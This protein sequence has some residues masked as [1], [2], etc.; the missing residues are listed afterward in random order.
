MSLIVSKNDGE[1]DLPNVSD[2]YKS[3][4][5][6]ISDSQI[7]DA[8]TA[9]RTFDK[10]G[11]AAAEFNDADTGIIDE[12]NNSPVDLN[13]GT[14]DSSPLNW[15]IPAALVILLIILGYAFCGSAPVA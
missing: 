6:N 14:L 5:G 8:P 15:I 3:G 4:A 2:S 7:I 1:N 12:L 10:I 13:T 9:S 11:T